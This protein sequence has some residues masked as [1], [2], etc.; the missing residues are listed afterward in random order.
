M[1]KPT[2]ACDS[3]GVP[4]IITHEADGWLVEPRSAEAVAAGIK[5]LLAD[6]ALCRRLGE[7]AR[8]TI[9]SR[10]SPR[11]QCALVAQKY[12]ALIPADTAAEEVST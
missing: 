7:Q 9:H 2:I 6:P 3:G 10:F 4:E 12:A 1:R 8:K 11:C 5:T